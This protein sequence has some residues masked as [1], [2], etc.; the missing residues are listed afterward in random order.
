M[1]TEERALIQCICDALIENAKPPPFQKQAPITNLI[2]LMR[3]A[4]FDIPKISP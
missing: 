1:T 2:D 4:G 3:I